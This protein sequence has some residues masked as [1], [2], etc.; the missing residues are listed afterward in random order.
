[1]TK[2]YVCE[3]S[4]LIKEAKTDEKAL[5][6]YLDKLGKERIEHILKNCKAE[7][8]ARSLGASLL[9]L[10]ALQQ[11]DVCVSKLPDFS[12]AENGKPYFKEFSEI[13]F[14]L[15]HTKN[16]I[17]CVISDVGVGVDIEHV[18]EI[19]DITI[20]RVFTEREKTFAGLDKEGYIKLW[21][22]KEACAKVQG[23]GL[24]DILNGLE[25]VESE[26][27]KIIQKLN[28]D[29]TKTFCYMIVAEGKVVDSNEYPYYYSVCSEISTNVELVQTKWDKNQIILSKL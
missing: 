5:D 29:I 3:I 1:M 23:K 17:A 28:Q 7:D 25:V 19:K 18:R 26:N 22:A 4:N 24:A 21:T 11:E 16:M 6:F 13:Y 15:S 14:N 20:N 27:G 9:L 10:F 2:L 12:Y 8:R